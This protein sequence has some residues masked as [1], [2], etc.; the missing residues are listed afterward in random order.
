MCSCM[1]KN[2]ID[3]KLQ[4]SKQYATAIYRSSLIQI[5]ELWLFCALFLSW[6]SPIYQSSANFLS[7]SS[8]MFILN[9]FYKVRE[10]RFWQSAKLIIVSMNFH[11]SW[12]YFFFIWINYETLAWLCSGLGSFTSL[13]LLLAFWNYKACKRCH[14]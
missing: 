10:Y 6:C 13:G 4:K 12:F 11:F 8:H 3:R 2:R 1:L 9:G 14:L 7:N 5:Q